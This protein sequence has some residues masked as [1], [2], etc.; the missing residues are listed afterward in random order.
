MGG[1]LLCRMRE[2]KASFVKKKM[3]DFEETSLDV[4]TA[5]WLPDIPSLQ[6]K[7]GLI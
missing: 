3:V 6:D 2:V 1:A 7:Q 4:A 5:S